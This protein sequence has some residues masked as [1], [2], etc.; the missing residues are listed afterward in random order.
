MVIQYP[1]ILEFEMVTADDPYT[2]QN[3]DVVVPDGI[4]RTVQVMCRFEPNSKGDTVPSTD[5]NQLTY[6][7]DVFAPLDQPDV[8]EQIDFK[9]Y[10]RDAKLI[11]TGV[12]KRFSRGQ[13][14]LTINV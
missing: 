11:A 4:K 10:N 2:D 7:W 14:N 12:V 13:M 3:G 6:S 8:P 9:G 1:D 5:G